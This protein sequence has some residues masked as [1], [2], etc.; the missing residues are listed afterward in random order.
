M[1]ESEEQR[2]NRELIEL[3]NELRVARKLG[4]RV[5]DVHPARH[6]AEHGVLA[7]EPRGRIC[8]DDEEL[9]AVRVRAGVRHRERAAFDLVLVELVLEGVAGTS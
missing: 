2:R 6:L 1:P 9:R 8:G 3:L 5:D 7:V 4:D